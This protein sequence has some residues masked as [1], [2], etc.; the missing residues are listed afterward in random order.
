MLAL[1]AVFT[2]LYAFVNAFGAWMAMRRKPWV[3]GLFMLA[4]A[5]LMVAAA[6]L[7]SVIPFTRVILAAGLLLASAASLSYARVVLGRVQWLHHL[8]R[9]LLELALYALANRAL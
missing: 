9:A 6:A 1:S 8:L 5:V 4:A 7:V 2:L 3:A